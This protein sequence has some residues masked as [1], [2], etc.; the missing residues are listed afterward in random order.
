[1][2]GVLE[3]IATKSIKE[4]EE[5]EKYEM[6]D[7]RLLPTP[8]VAVERCRSVANTMAELSVQSV[9]KALLQFTEYKPD[10]AEEIISNEKKVDKYEDKLGSYLVKLCACE[11]TDADSAEATKLLHAIS[12][13][14]RLSDHAVSLVKSAQ[15]INEK[16]LAFSDGKSDLSFGWNGEIA[17]GGL[18]ERAWL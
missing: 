7:E 11:L 5:T 10:E 13:L 14:E 2:L 4:T 17:G 15:E 8:A 1:M 16:K 18:L 3:K 12:D 6:L 9:Y